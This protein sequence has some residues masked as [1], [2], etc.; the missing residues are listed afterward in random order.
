MASP[1]YSTHDAAPDTA[2]EQP[3]DPGPSHGPVPTSI[4][5]YVLG[6]QFETLLRRL[7]P[8]MRASL[9]DYAE[10]VRL[11]LGHIVSQLRQFG[12]GSLQP[13]S[14]SFFPG[15]WN[16]T[17]DAIQRNSADLSEDGL[18]KECQWSPE[19]S[20]ESAERT[21]SAELQLSDSA[22]ALPQHSD[23][24]HIGSQFDDRFQWPSYPEDSPRD[25]EFG[26]DESRAWS[27][28]PEGDVRDG[29]QA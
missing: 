14:S 8:D 13:G 7:R 4:S 12:Q 16:S 21:N 9:E 2:I 17:L 11:G 24:A 26:E 18:R 19:Q 25:L 28:S 27:E 29:Q 23:F 10:P 3:T 15:E 22:Q 20:P 1:L 5:F 6:R